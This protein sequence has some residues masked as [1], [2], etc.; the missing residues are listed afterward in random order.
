GVLNGLDVNWLL[1]DVAAGETVT[2]NLVVRSADGLADGVEIVAQ[3][4]GTAAADPRGEQLSNE[5]RVTVN[6]LRV[7]NLE[8]LKTP[9]TVNVL[10]GES[11]TYTIRVRNVG[12]AAARNVVVTDALP[13]GTVFES[14]TAGGV[15]G[16]GTVTWNVAEI[17]AGGEVVLELVLG[18][19]ANTVAGTVIRNIAVADSPDDPDGPK[20]NAPDPDTDVRVETL[21]NLAIMKRSDTPVAIA[22]ENLAYT[23]TVTNN[24]PSDAQEVVVTDPIPVGTSFV[25]AD[26]GGMLA[27]GIVTWNVGTIPAG[28]T[29]TLSLVVLVDANLA[30]GT[31]ISNIARVESPTD[32]D[33][34]KESDPDETP[35]VNERADL[36]V[37]KVADVTTVL[38]GDTFG[39]TITIRNTGN[40]PATQVRVSDPLPAGTEFVRADN[41]GVF[42]NGVVRWEIPVIAAGE[43]ISLRLEVRVSE[44]ITV[45]SIVN[46]A[47]AESP[48]DP[49]GPKSN[50]PG[51][52][53]TV[54]FRADLV[55]EKI[56]ESA[57]V[58]AGE[59][60]TYTIRV[61][62]IGAGVAENVLVRDVL[63]PALSFVSADNAGAFESGVVTWNL[64]AIAANETVVLQLQ[65][66]VDPLLTAETTI[67]NIATVISPSDPGGE[68]AS[69]PEVITV[70]P[71]QTTIEVTK[72]ADSDR[73]SV[74]DQ[75]AF[76][77]TVRNT[78]TSPAIGLIVVD[79]IPESLMILSISGNAVSTGNRITWTVPVLQPGQQ[80]TLTVVTMV[81][82]EGAAIVNTV[83]VSGENVPDEEAS[84]DP[85]GFN[86]ADLEITKEVSAA[87]VQVGKQFEYRLKVR[88]LS[89]N[90]ANEVI[91]TDFIPLATR[92]VDASPSAGTVSYDNTTRVLT[93]TVDALAGGEEVMLSIRVVAEKASELVSNTARVTARERDPDESNNV[94][95][96]QHA[97]LEFRIP[98]TFTPNG[99]GI[100]DTFEVPGLE[101]FFPVRQLLI[102]NRWGVEVFRSAN[103][104]N[105][106]DGGNLN[107]GTYFYQFTLRDAQDAEIVL[108]GYVTILR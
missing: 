76:T 37:I 71:G 86:T 36:E 74:G 7:A 19:P 97:Q 15:F 101:A 3:A 24:G 77:I 56:A 62:N 28:E 65:V 81:I 73:V 79:D 16:G 89:A 72:V 107:E 75:L 2:L 64:A 43:S 95:N 40:A 50:E 90:T 96:V 48:D 87:V 106:W 34:P 69:D 105:D 70:N 32:P 100:N 67:E 6:A 12:N 9:A 98:N 55:I 61:R 5:V 58:N 93:W 38:P 44:T 80:V 41:G 51:D 27:N 84:T 60:V 82:S 66:R 91:V 49:D 35:V 78:G 39:Y 31:V 22:G 94:A 99:D 63:N 68:K 88:N 21:A 33:T 102:V 83:L 8:V 25:S 1:A 26:M 104:A 14:A 18:I 10:A 23:I 53:V 103:Y 42:E 47:T 92:F 52:G 20:E 29:V 11:I 108:T 59:L 85:I 4:R 17:A 13:A 57:V 46:I 45:P 30:D 54:D